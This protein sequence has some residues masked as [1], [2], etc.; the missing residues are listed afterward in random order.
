MLSGR[1]RLVLGE[2]D[3]VLQP[4]EAAAFDTRVLHWF[5]RAGRE[6]VELLSLVGPQGEMVSPA[7]GRLVARPYSGPPD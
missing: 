6:P 3:L 2:H 7:S 4:G 5:D 1:L